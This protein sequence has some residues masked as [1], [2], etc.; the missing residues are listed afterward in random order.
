MAYTVRRLRPADL[1]A[2]FRL[3]WD[4]F[5]EFE[6]PDYGP[7]GVDA[8]RQSIMENAPFRDACRNG[9]NRMWGAFEGA[10]LA[11]VWGMR[12]LTHICLVFTHREH[13][14]KGVAT[15]IFHRLLEDL[16]AE[17]PEVTR[18]TLNSSPYGLP[19]YHRIGFVDTAPEQSVDG[20]RFTPMAYDLHRA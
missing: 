15:M 11:G 7:E 5:L 13:H 20:I 17:A 16:R 12:G 10:A 4:T 3:I 9:E 2:A 1:D 19:F 6:A 14:R 18:L 8:F